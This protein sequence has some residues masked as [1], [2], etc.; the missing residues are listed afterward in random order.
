MYA[1]TFPPLF[2]PDPEHFQDGVVHELI[3]WR[4]LQNRA[5][6]Q[7]LHFRNFKILTYYLYAAVLKSLRL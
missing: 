4:T 1:Y 5:F 7:I 6:V 2:S 3:S